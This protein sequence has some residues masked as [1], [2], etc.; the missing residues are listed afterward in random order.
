V[1]SVFCRP[2]R[3]T[4]W[5]APNHFR[6]GRDSL[7]TGHA[8]GQLR[9]RCGTGCHTNRCACV[10]NR[11]PCLEGCRC[12]NCRNP[13]NGLD[14]TRM[15]PCALD[16]VERYKAPSEAELD[17]MMELICGCEQLPLRRL[18]AAY[19]CNGCDDLSWYSFCSHDVVQDSCT[20]HCSDCGACRDWREWH[21][22]RCN[23]CTYGVTMPCEN[24][25]RRE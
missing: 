15:S 7:M 4:T 14:G 13:F 25:G 12:S 20:W 10:R 9:C 3:P 2:T 11:Q 6:T 16:N 22:H 24:C 21:C 18:L 1:S 5:L 19:R 17:T 8:H 23:R